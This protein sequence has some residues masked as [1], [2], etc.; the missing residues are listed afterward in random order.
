M[1]KWVLIVIIVLFQL[2][3]FA[4]YQL[5]EQNDSIND[6][7]YVFYLN[8]TLRV[9]S[10][11]KGKVY[12]YVIGPHNYLEVKSVANLCCDYATLM[13]VYSAKPD[14]IQK[15]KE[16]DSIAVISEVH[17]N[18]NDYLKLLIA[19]GIL[20]VNRNWNYGK[21]HLVFLGDAFDRGDN[22]TELLW[23]LFALE[24]QAAKDGGV[25]HVLL[26]NHES[27]IFSNDLRYI[28]EKY[29]KVETITKT[30]YYKLY[31]E[32]S[33]LG[34]WLRSQPVIITINDILFVHAGIS[35]EL[36]R[37][38]LSIKEVNKLFYANIFGAKPPSINEM[39]KIN[40]LEGNNG[41]LWYRG[42]FEDK[43]FNE[44]KLDSILNN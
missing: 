20:D 10:I 22:V 44:T 27:M 14:F 41:P 36:V 30:P 2:N 25:V 15:F 23:H 39:E 5:K 16:V 12:H 32:N 31:A 42:Y 13:N 34:K 33:V 37:S 6:G 1:K 4:I 19:N 40:L 29:K 35:M 11:E 18:Y 8:D 26:G 28:S 3:G 21:G 43:T 17:G 24:K 7:P 9:E 38:K